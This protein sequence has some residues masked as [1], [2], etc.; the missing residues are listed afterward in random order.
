MVA[1]ADLIL[2]FGG[3]IPEF[4]GRKVVISGGHTEE[5]L[6]GVRFLSNRSSGKTAAAIARA[7]R[8]CG[9]EVHLV[10]GRAD[11]PGPNGIHVT[12]VR[13]SEEFRTALK[14]GQPGADAVIMAAAIADFVPAGPGTGAGT[15]KW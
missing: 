4:E 5:P 10:L 6:D 15:E 14:S 8:L 3:N 13:T 11:E 1:Y 2:E 9:A 7:M 12:R